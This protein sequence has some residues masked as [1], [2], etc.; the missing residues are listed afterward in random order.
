MWVFSF[1][2]SHT[3]PWFTSNLDAIRLW[4][5]PSQ[6]KSHTWTASS[7]VSRR[8]ACFSR[9]NVSAFRSLIANWPLDLCRPYGPMGLSL[10]DPAAASTVGEEMGTRAVG[11]SGKFSRRLYI[12]ALSSTGSLR[13]LERARQ[14]SPSR[15]IRLWSGVARPWKGGEI[16]S[17]SVHNIQFGGIGFFRRRSEFDPNL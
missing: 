2:T 11:G 9:L 10:S 8:L 15:L 6:C 1:R 13:E 7:A 12:P 3:R 16:L 4:I 5:I 14:D 17:Q